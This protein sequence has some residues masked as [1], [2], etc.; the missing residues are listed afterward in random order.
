MRI[1]KG[2]EQAYRTAHENV[3][4]SVIQSI[5]RVRIHNYS[6]YMAGQDLYSYFEVED[7]ALAMADLKDDIENQKW[8]TFMAPL[9]EINAGIKDQASVYFEE[10]IHI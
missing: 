8:Q 9:M 5:D 3:W 4:D 2:S 10:I 7:L 1:K 6:I